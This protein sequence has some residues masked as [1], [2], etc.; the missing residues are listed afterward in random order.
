MY[1]P[2][3]RPDQIHSL[4]LLKLEQGRP[5]TTLARE[6]VDRYLRRFHRGTQPSKAA[7]EE[8]TPATGERRPGSALRDRHD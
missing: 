6:A 1:Q 4:Y 3:L 2:A 7:G 8:L 5:M